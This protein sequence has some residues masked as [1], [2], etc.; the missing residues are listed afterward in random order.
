MFTL[1]DNLI[2]VA[3]QTAATM[4]GNAELLPDC[5]GMTLVRY[6]TPE[7]AERLADATVLFIPIN[8]D[9]IPYLLGSR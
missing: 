4:T 8:I 5:N 9:R 7:A 1:P 6:G 3:R 2:A